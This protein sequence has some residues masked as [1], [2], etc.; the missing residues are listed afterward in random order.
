MARRALHTPPAARG[1]QEARYLFEGEIWHDAEVAGFFGI[2]IRT[3]KRRLDSPKSGEIDINWAE[4][5]R[6]G[7]R[8]YWLRSRVMELVG[9]GDTTQQRKG[10]TL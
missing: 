8:R 3:L 9:I 2:S 6:F 10:Q 5:M 1:D 4:P 7:G